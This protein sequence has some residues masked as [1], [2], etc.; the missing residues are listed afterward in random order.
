MRPLKIL[1]ALHGFPPEFK[2]GTELYVRN[3]VRALESLGHSSL[4]LAGS[5]VRAASDR[6]DRE[7][8]E[9]IPVL[10]LHR[11]GFSHEEWRRSRSPAVES[12]V[13]EVLEAERPDVFHIHHWY[14]LTRTLA[15][16]ARRAGVPSVLTFH[17]LWST[18]AKAFRLRDE[19]FCEARFLEVDCERCVPSRPWQEAAETRTDLAIHRRDLAC[20]IACASA[21]L[22]PIRAHRDRIA[23][24]HGIEPERIRVLHLGPVSE[25]HSECRTG[26]RRFPD[27]PLRI[28]HWAHMDVCKGSHVLLEAAR[29]I[30]ASD[31]VEFHLLGGF[32]TPEYEAR[33][34]G[35]AEGLPVTFHGPFVPADLARAALDVAVIP[36]VTAESY[37]FVVDEAM[38]LGL[39]ALVSDLGAL[40]ER[41]GEAGASFPPGDA[42][43]LASRI[44]SILDDPSLLDRWRA[45]IPKDRGTMEAHAADVA[46]VYEE[47]RTAPL[48]SGEAADRIVPGDAELL[49]LRADQ[50]DAR[51]VA[52]L[53][54]DARAE[55]HM[56]KGWR[57]ES[58]LFLA[59]Q[60]AN[61]LRE[62][63]EAAE[64]ERD[65]VRA[66][67][68]AAESSLAGWNEV[69]KGRVTGPAA[70]LL[71]A[72]ARWRKGRIR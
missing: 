37:S 63:L 12:L 2:G 71:R 32:V 36:S 55:Y 47:V 6:I 39:P 42:E 15:A 41:I 51:D 14:R 4:V 44:R 53:A 33:L 40:P 29:A 26:D 5:G 1:H 8:H 20:E 64:G 48:P 59:R 69:E 56:L 7:E 70:G 68:E 57:L 17:D 16:V 31:R 50:L 45:A 49:R 23:A 11:S 38:Q 21:L 18:C 19:K 34:R 46:R 62:R 60:E 27:G 52:L 9:G 43:A 54:A 61:G 72:I 3:L 28:G 30:G 35:L 65:G 25:L 22:A 67:L 13:A 66:R 10:R 24:L 58:D